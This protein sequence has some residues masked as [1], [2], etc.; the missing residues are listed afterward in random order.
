[1]SY[2]EGTGANRRKL[3]RVR[4]RLQV[5]VKVRSGVLT[6]GRMQ[7]GVA[8]DYNRYGMALICPLN[9]RPKTRLLLDI[10]SDH[11]L[12]RRV[13][14]QVVS[15]VKAGREYRLGIRFYRKLTDFAEPG[16]GHPLHFLMGLEQ[17]IAE[18][19]QS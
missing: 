1:M 14:A 12:L 2:R 17:S 10:G 13:R 5:S 9:L 4:T 16:P 8:V 19:V 6:R 7:S 18:P 11:M 3:D 15:S